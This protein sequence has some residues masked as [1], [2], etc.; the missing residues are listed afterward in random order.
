MRRHDRGHEEQRHHHDEADHLEAQRHSPDCPA[1]IERQER[2]Q[3]EEVDDEVE[4]S[5]PEEQRLPRGGVQP[6]R[7]EP[8]ERSEHRAGE[9]DPRLGQSVLRHLL[10]RHEGAQEGD[11]HG[12][13]SRDALAPQLQDVAHLVDPDQDDYPHREPHWEEQGVQPRCSTSMVSAVPIN[14]TLSRRSARPLNFTSSTPITA[15]GARRR[16]ITLQALS[17]FEGL[18]RRLRPWPF[19]VAAEDW[20]SRLV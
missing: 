13:R 18:V 17:G 14:L 6:E 19:E 12:G 1:T 3:V 16:L 11:E 7:G 4:V 9:P 20:L 5:E 8:A 15:S 10:H 2:R